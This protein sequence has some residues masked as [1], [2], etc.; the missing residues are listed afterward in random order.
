MKNEFLSAFKIIS[1]SIKLWWGDWVNQVLVSLAATLISL[2][3]ILAPAALMGIFQQA[4][5]LTHGTR[6]G[7]IGWWQGFKRY[8]LKG[9]IWGIVNFLVL[10]V[11]VVSVWFYFNLKIGWA[12]LLM[13][14]VILIGLFW[15]TLQFYSLGYFFE[16]Q[17]KS[18][19]LA[20]KNS[21]LTI[22]G[23]PFFSLILGL[24]NLIL[25]GVSLTTFLPLIIGTPSLLGILNV[26]AVHDRL[27]TYQKIE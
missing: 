6:T 10:T 14:I 27:V 15:L 12:P 17:E 9:L 26:Q 2:T 21:F 19:K 8:F 18:I 4:Q 20:W 25:T 1:Q 22:L 13:I 24:F 16:Q 5:D 23:A 3:I 7:I 11:I